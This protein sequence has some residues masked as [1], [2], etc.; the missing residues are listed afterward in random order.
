MSSL[1][2]ELAPGSTGIIVFPGGGLGDDLDDPSRPTLNEYCGR[3]DDGNDLVWE[4]LDDIDTTPPG[5]LLFGL[6][7]PNSENLMY[8]AGG[9][10]KG[11]T[12]AWL[13]RECQAAG[14]RVMIYD[15]EL[16]GGEWARRCEGLGVQR[17]AVVYVQPKHLPGH[18]LGRPLPD[19]VPHLGRIAKATGCGLL[20]IDSIIAASNLTEDGLKSDAGIPYAYARALAPLGLTSVLI[21]HPNKANPAGDPYGSVA[22]VLAMRLVWLGTRAESDGH[23]VRWSVRKRN[24][25]GRIKP[26]LFSF[27]YDPLSNQ[28]IAAKKEDDEVVTRAW[29][30]DALVQG[31]RTTKDLADE[32]S[33]LM[34]DT[35]DAERKA[36][37][38]RLK[39]MLGRMRKAGDVHLTGS[40]GSP[41]SLGASPNGQKMSP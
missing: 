3:D 12:M 19:V 39:K 31:P 20:I 11:M 15:A 14:I 23:R 5:P 4:T 8:A 2:N 28:L 38:E 29:L 17:K 33:D 21:G 13:I 26:L 34:D 6:L 40:K 22:W 16:H 36:T 35:T 10:G 25:R 30:I 7:E 37:H 41:W 18:L 32:L 9:V 24:E 1:L 27:D